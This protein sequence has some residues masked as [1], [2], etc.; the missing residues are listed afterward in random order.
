MSK[1]YTIFYNRVGEH[2]GINIHQGL[3]P[4][5]KELI[6]VTEVKLK[7]EECDLEYSALLDYDTSEEVICLHKSDWYKNNIDNR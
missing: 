7:R 1:Y 3:I 4:A 2:G 5:L 6:E